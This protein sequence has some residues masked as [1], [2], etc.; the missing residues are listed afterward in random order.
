MRVFGLGTVSYSGDT[1][2]RLKVPTA[3]ASS[4]ASR[5][6]ALPLPRRHHAEVRS[7]ATTTNR[8]NPDR[9]ACLDGSAGGHVR[10]KDEDRHQDGHASKETAGDPADR[11]QVSSGRREAPYG[12]RE[13]DSDSEAGTRK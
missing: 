12:E 1:A 6:T 13:V 10:V 11:W 5:C 8:A 2:L 9:L 4:Q 3:S 7:I